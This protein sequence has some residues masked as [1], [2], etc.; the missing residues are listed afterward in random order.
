MNGVV[1]VIAGAPA[2]VNVAIRDAPGRFDPP[3]VNVGPGGTVTWTNF[4]IQMHTVTE[5]GGAGSLENWCINGRSFVGNTPVI[6]AKSGTR[7]RWYVFNLDLGPMWHNFHTHGQRWQWGHENVDTRS[8]GPAESFVA[9]TRVPDVVLPPC[10]TKEPE[11][12]DLKEFHLCGD[13]PVHCHV[14]HHMMQGMVALVR[15][16]QHLALTKDEYRSLRFKPNHYC[17]P[18]DHGGHGGCPH[19]DH[20]RCATAGGGSWEPLPDVPI[21]V[22][23]AA[24]LRTGRVL[25]FSGTAE[26]G[27]PTNSYLFDPAT[28]AYVGPQAYAEDLFCSGHTFLP[29]GRLLVAGGAPQF[30]MASTHVFDPAAESWTKL[31]G[32]DMAHGRWYP[33]LVPLA[34]GRVFAASGRIGVQPME[35]FDPTTSSWTT[36]AGADKDFS[37]LYPSLHL[38]PTGQIFYSRTGWAAMS[39]AS[40]SRLDFS[41]PTAGAWTDQSPMTFPDRQEGAS[42]ILVDET[43]SPPNVRVIVFGGGVSGVFNKQSCEMI[44]AT[45]LTPAPS[46]VRMADMTFPRTNVNGVI[47]PDGTVLAIG[48]QRNGKWAA[49]PN[50][51]LEPELFD[52]ASNRWT[53]LAPMTSPRQYHSI[54]VLLPDGRVLAAGGIDPTLGGA[55]ARDLRTVEI[56]SPPYLSSG[57]RPVISSVAASAAFASS[58]TI[59]SPDAGGI[60]AVALLRPAAVTH[61][62][63]A[64]QRY[65]RLRILGRTGT[66]VTV[67]MPANGHVAPPGHYMLFLLNAAGVPSRAAWV[68]L[69]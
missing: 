54:A 66:S 36:V 12:R 15:A 23:H 16:Q 9:D 49:S 52:P 24:V 14:E 29:D 25:L 6:E 30:F 53:V 48:G 51:V 31:T 57:S 28:N 1:N 3:T 26:V 21:F 61:H 11:H 13:F 19:V 58:L 10:R 5:R 8:L 34:D 33:T 60:T 43:V 62:T 20:D 40:T 50:P 59:D 47:L 67:R 39:G 32:H 64:G 37:Q 18:A 44:D 42:V 45:S 63:D 56:F 69:T 38:L 46:W 65:I 55:P 35:V 22:V 68:R 7:V 17:M 27:Y 41:G 4:G 2:A